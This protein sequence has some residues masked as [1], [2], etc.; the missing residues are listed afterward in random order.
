[1]TKHTQLYSLYYSTIENNKW[2]LLVSDTKDMHKL[3]HAMLK[4]L[5]DNDIREVDESIEETIVEALD[6]GDET[7]ERILKILQDPINEGE[8]G[9]ILIHAMTINEE[10]DGVYGIFYIHKG[11]EKVIY[12]DDPC[13]FECTFMSNEKNFSVHG[14]NDDSVF[15]FEQIPVEN[16]HVCKKIKL[17]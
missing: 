5:L 8:L 4:Q 9:D 12:L 2:E 3:N 15:Y 11:D 13:D 16:E 14:V 1:M 6:S 17:E 7:N 10:N